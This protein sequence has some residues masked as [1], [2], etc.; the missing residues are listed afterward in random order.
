MKSNWKVTIYPYNC[1]RK[2]FQDK[3]LVGGSYNS[4]G[5]NRKDR[6]IVSRVKNFRFFNKCVGNQFSF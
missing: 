4:G 3:I 6:V 5:K 2:K 1:I